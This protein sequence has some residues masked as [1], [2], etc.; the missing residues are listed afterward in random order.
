MKS[1]QK[2]I[3]RVSEVQERAAEVA[4]RY[5][6]EQLL[7][8]GILDASK[9]PYNA[10]NTGKRD[11]SDALEAALRDARDAQ[12]VCYL[13]AGEYLVS[14]T[15]VGVQGIVDWDDWPYG[16][17]LLSN[18]CFSEASFEYP[19]VLMGPR[20][21]SRARIRLQDGAPGFDDPDSPKPV[22]YFW[23]RSHRASNPDPEA[24][25]P[26]ISFNQKIMSLDFDL[27]SSNP[28]AIAIDHRGAEGCTVE[29]VDISATGAFAG[30]KDAP[31]SGG[32]MHRISVEGGRY[33]LYISGSQP[34]PLVSD[35][36]L[37]AQTKHSIFFQSS[38][39]LCLV[40]AKIKGKGISGAG[41]N[42]NFNGA[43]TM[44]DVSIDCD[45][46]SPAIQAKRSLVL[47]NVWI[48]GSDC[49]VDVEGR[50][51]AHGRSGQ[52]R[53]IVHF[54]YG[55]EANYREAIEN[56]P[57]RDKLWLDRIEQ[58]QPIFT[59]DSPKRDPQDFRKAHAYRM[60][61]D[62]RD[63]VN[64][65]AAPYK[66][67]GDGIADDTNAIQNAI[68]TGSPVFLPKGRYLI[69]QPLRLRKDSLLFG[70]S[71]IRSIV[72]ARNEK[73]P[74]IHDPKAPFS[75]PT[76]PD[77][78]IDTPDAADGTALLA[79]LR[80]EQPAL[81]P[82]VTALEWKLGRRSTVQNIY[83][84]QSPY[85]SAASLKTFP[86]IRIC[87]G[88]GGSWYNAQNYDYWRQGPDYRSVLVEGTSE[89][90]R[91]YHLQPQF[92]ASESMVEFKDAANIDVFS[93]KSEGDCSVIWITRCRNVR[94]L[95]L[96][97]L[98][99]PRPGREVIRISDCQDLLLS[100]IAPMV[101]G[102]GMVFWGDFI[103]FHLGACKLLQDGG[104]TINGLE[105]FALYQLGNPSG[106]TTDAICKVSNPD[107]DA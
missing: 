24:S 55:S 71:N 84:H 96:S 87:K 43:L 72:T 95:G 62:I 1:A 52:W 2:P 104:F 16:D 86:L 19:N 29:D 98:I 64:A 32:S 54:A 35:L 46:R 34:S 39:A 67:K 53:R 83:A 13:P 41:S 69:T 88:G 58:R 61:P 99:A 78:L 37:R 82:C 60:L 26:S 50:A 79:M 80:L 47:Q 77:P 68:D 11:S 90:L 40:G 45:T 7:S 51:F 44:I 73:P 56:K 8:D 20:G 9:A 31:G 21:E 30:I 102:Q 100:H 59:V 10:D 65:R 28:G 22:V 74:R 48:R 57:W 25:C 81:N 15:I 66:A 23:A 93:A 101:I 94:F 6:D 38:G 5:A 70:L 92:N 33:G 36:T 103:A 49:L 27:G 4:A 75:N 42:L 63:A 18:P 89:P 76:S 97:G 17:P 106:A 105:Q 14:R 107:V 12:A 91:F 85:H 3:R